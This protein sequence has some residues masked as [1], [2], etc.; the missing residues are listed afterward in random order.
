MNDEIW[1]AIIHNDSSYDGSFFYGVMTT[2][3]FCR[4]SCKSKNPNKEHVKIFQTADQALAEKFRPCKRCRP[5]GQRMPDQ[6]WVAQISEF[7]ERHYP[8]QLTLQVLADSLHA[9]PYHLQRTFKRVRGMTPAEYVQRIRLEAAKERLAQTD[10][11]VTDIAASV[12]IPN[13]GH[14]ATV[15]QKKTGLS[16][17]D[18]RM[19]AATKPQERRDGYGKR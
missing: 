4:P 15:F 14:F 9:S 2:G 10:Q 19:A 7:I 8:E 5:D 18:Y 3:I 13:A 11:A 17:T 1:N 16:P 6:E 12:G